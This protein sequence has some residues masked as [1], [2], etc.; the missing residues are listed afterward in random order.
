LYG[1]AGD[2]SL[3]GGQGKDRLDGGSGFNRYQTK[4]GFKDLIYGGSDV[5]SLTASDS[6]DVTFGVP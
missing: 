3:I 5:D 1:E 6:F 4:D 2:D